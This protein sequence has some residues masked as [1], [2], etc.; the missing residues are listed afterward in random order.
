MASVNSV[1]LLGTVA[2]EVRHTQTDKSQV[3]NFSL[4]TDALSI[5]GKAYSSWH[6]IVVWGRGAEMVKDLSEGD[7]LT[8]FGEL[9]TESW[10]SDGEKK[11]K[12][13][14]KAHRVQLA[15]EEGQANAPF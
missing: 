5:N 12:S 6:N 1:T 11:Y 15:S 10:E 3:S 4:K 2:S 8:V 14:V 13:V 9:G 7:M